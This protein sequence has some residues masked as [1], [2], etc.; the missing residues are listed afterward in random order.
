L[1]VASYPGGAPSQEVLA[2]GFTLVKTFS[3]SNLAITY[4][5]GRTQQN[6]ITALSGDRGD[7]TYSFRF[8][9]RFMWDNG[10]GYYREIGV[11]SA[12][13]G[14]AAS[15]VQFALSKMFALSGTYSYITQR[16]S[17]PQLLSGD[18]KMIMFGISWQP[19]LV[20]AH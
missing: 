2:G 6:F 15:K 3:S 9:R 16:S 1:D 4:G 12:R 19:A 17:T 10:A 5:R 18:L 11:N 8:L 20:G 7:L 13:G 14:Y